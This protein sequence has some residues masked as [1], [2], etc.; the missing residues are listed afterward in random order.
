[1]HVTPPPPP[2][3]GWQ[4][5]LV[6]V[7][8]SAHGV[9]A[10][11]A[12]HWPSAH[13]FPSP[14]SLENLHVFAGEVHEPPT[15]AWPLAQS[16]AAVAAV[17]GH[18]PAEPPHASQVFATQALPSPQSAFVVQSFFAPGS[19]VGA[20]QRPFLQTSPFAHGMLSEHVAVQPVAVQT[21]PAAQLE[22]P[23]HACFVGGATVEQPYASHW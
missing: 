10:Q 1:V 9:D 21:E 14:H 19:T 6:Q 7:N 13:T 12:R 5:P 22:A 3:V 20:A 2:G 18:G 17:Q 11:P 16:V 4:A 15:H 8:P 23:V